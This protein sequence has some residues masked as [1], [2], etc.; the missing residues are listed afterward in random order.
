MLVDLNNLKIKARTQDFLEIEEI[1]NNLVILKNGTVSAIIEVFPSN[2]ELLSLE[3]QQYRIRA[4]ASLINSVEYPLQILIE[5]KQ[6][7]TNEYLRFLDSHSPNI[8]N[9]ALSRMYKIYS[10]FM[11][12]ILSQ[13][14]VF[15]KRFFVVVSYYSIFKYS[16]DLPVEQKKQ[17]LERALNYLVPKVNH[18]IQVF[19]N[20]GMEAKLLSTFEIIK[21][22]YSVYNPESLQIDLTKYKITLE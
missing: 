9:N 3:E 11:H 13:Q 7:R 16:A 2:F 21:Y 15:K 22:F 10:H 18:I 8:K 19:K 1:V 14:K 5:T 4:F 6:V 12:N 20:M 17:L